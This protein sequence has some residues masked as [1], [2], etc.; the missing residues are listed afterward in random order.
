VRL[1]QRTRNLEP[2][3]FNELKLR[4]T[5]QAAS[6]ASLAQGVRTLGSRDGGGTWFFSRTSSATCGRAE[7]FGEPATLPYGAS[8]RRGGEH[9]G[10]ERG[11]DGSASHGTSLIDVARMERLLNQKAALALPRNR[12]NF[13]EIFF[14]SEFPVGAFGPCLCTQ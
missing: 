9:E 6:A 12:T 10:Q 8:E 11:R 3:V 2:A 1:L 5:P 7:D 4:K 13:S 14:P